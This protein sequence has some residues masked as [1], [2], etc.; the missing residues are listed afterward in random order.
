MY[1]NPTHNSRTRGGTSKQMLV[2]VGRK[3]YEYFCLRS[4]DVHVINLLRTVIL[5]SPPKSKVGGY[6]GM[7][8]G[9]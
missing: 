3:T 5:L 8:E 9:E 4:D 7:R 1:L 6:M 2:R